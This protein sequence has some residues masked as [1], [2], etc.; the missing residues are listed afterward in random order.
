MKYRTCFF[1]ITAFMLTVAVTRAQP[2]GPLFTLMKEK[3]TGVQFINTIKEDDSL[4][5]MNYEY[6]YNGHGI[7]VAD[8]NGDGW[9]DLFFSGNMVPNKLFL[10][11][12]SFTFKDVTAGAGIKGNGTWSTGVSVA[13][14]NGDRLPDIY[15]CH[16]GKYA[17]EKQLSNELYI[18]KGLKNGAPF[19]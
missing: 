12:R 9:P 10:N 2:A 6:L 8:F 15:V 13:D 4:H 16:S 5:V 11:T 1:W 19:F 7:G 14:V 17:N 18:N 3:Q